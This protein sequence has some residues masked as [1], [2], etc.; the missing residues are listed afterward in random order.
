MDKESVLALQVLGDAYL[1]AYSEV[2]RT[3]PNHDTVLANCHLR[4]GYFYLQKSD[5]DLQRTIEE[6]NK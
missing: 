1:K 6:L 3:I 4:S 5:I 2:I